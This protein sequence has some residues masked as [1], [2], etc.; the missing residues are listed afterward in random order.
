MRSRTAFT[1]VEL[2]VVIGVIA[3]LI[4]MLL[5]ALAKARAAALSANCLSNL[6]Q[7]YTGFQMYSAD[8]RG[9]IPVMRSKSGGI[10]L[11]PWY[12]IAGHDTA[13]SPTGRSYI[14]QAVTICPAAPR[15]EQE[16]IV[17]DS[18][19]KLLGYGLFWVDS[20][21]SQWVFRSAK[22]QTVTQIGTDTWFHWQK[23]S[24]LPTPPTDTIMLADSLVQRP[25]A[26]YYGPG[27]ASTVA[28]FSDQDRG[29]YHGGRI[30]TRHGTDKYGSANVCFYD[31]HAATLPAGDLRNR[32]ASRIRKI[33]DK[34]W[35]DIT[36]P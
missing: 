10:V 27:P 25:G 1:L 23:L 11:W 36:L 3:L 34:D 21:R 28:A 6:R 9:D 24:R 14:P 19:A 31:G 7:V 17:K 5:P 33:W 16:R 4:A 29:P 18:D 15:F 20:G 22:F 32:T 26:P 2:L 13:D 30:H 35:R 12:L 8:H